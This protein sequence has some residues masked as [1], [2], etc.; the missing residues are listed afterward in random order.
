M[1][2]VSNLFSTTGERLRNTYVISN[3]SVTCLV[4]PKL[5]FWRH[6]HMSLLSQMRDQ[7][8]ASIPPEEKLSRLYWEAA[9]WDRYKKNI[10]TEVRQRRHIPKS[11]K[12]EDVPRSIR[13][14]SSEFLNLTLPAVTTKNAEPEAE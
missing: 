4:V 3:K 7:L 13:E 14:E 11:T 1:F 10:A 8:E 9:K 2:Y 5:M 12:W 6:G